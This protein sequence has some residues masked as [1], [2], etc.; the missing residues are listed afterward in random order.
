MTQKIEVGQ[1]VTALDLAQ[2]LDDQEGTF[3]CQQAGQSYL[4]VSK[5]GHSITSLRPIGRRFIEAAPASSGQEA[6]VVER[7]SHQEISLGQSADAEYAN[8]RRG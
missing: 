3:I 8:Q 2:L 4:A 5:K 7:I 1:R 6:W